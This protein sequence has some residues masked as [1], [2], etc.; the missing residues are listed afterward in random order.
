MPRGF[1]IFFRQ[2]KIHSLQVA[3][4]D[5]MLPFGVNLVIVII[6]HDSDPHSHSLSLELSSVSANDLAFPMIKNS[7]KSELTWT[8]SWPSQV[9][10]DLDLCPMWLKF[11]AWWFVISLPW[12]TVVRDHPPIKVVKSRGVGYPISAS[13]SICIADTSSNL[14]KSKWAVFDWAHLDLCLNWL[15]P[16][17]YQQAQHQAQVVWS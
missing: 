14:S 10:W 6:T 4:W 5:E 11:C 9:P 13:G 15:R 12:C 8:W 2:V 16:D 7:A 1:W 17:M 3:N